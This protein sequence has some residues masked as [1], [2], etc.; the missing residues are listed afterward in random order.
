MCFFFLFPWWALIHEGAANVIHRLELESVETEYFDL[1]PEYV[2]DCLKLPHVK[3]YLKASRYRKPVYLI[4]GV[5]VGNGVS[6]H[7]VWQPKTQTIRDPEA[8]CNCFCMKKNKQ[9]RAEENAETENTQTFSGYDDI[10]VAIQCLKI[11]QRNGCSARRRR[12]SG[13]PVESLS[14]QLAR[15]CRKRHI[16]LILPDSEED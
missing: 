1:T 13:S 7:I 15:S 10:V 14:T 5:K 4:T 3:E 16:K 8:G 11:S 9:S 6:A 12:A 2:S